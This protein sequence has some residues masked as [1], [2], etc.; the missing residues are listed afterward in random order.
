MYVYLDLEAGSTTVDLP[1]NPMQ[2]TAILH[3]R[4]SSSL[5]IPTT[6]HVTKTLL[7]KR[8]F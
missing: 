2:C 4:R 6:C 7:V 8:V 1:P 5:D 3:P